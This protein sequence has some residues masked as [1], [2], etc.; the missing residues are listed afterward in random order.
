MGL[1]VAGQS[2]EDSVPVRVLCGGVEII[3]GRKPACLA[4]C[5]EGWTI[6]G[7][8]YQTV[9]VDTT[10]ESGEP[11]VIYNVRLAGPVR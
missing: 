9:T 4:H 10:T 11:V 5:S 7:T 1:M 3:R 8:E 2:P 6:E